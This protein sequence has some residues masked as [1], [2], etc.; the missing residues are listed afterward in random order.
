MASVIVFKNGFLSIDGTEYTEQ[1]RSVTLTYSA[2][3]L[4]KTAMGDDTRTRTG[5]LKDWSVT[6]EAFNDANALD[7]K[8]FS[9]VGSSTFTVAVRATTSAASTS[10]PQYS[11]T[12]FLQTYNPVAGN[13]G[14]LMTTPIT[15]MSAGDLSKTTS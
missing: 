15:L 8:L 14:E 11:G 1:V 6:V 7:A 12:A 13:V 10:N 9:L 4:D 5:G 3:A 2:E